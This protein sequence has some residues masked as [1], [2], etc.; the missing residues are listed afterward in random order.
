MLPAHAASAPY[1]KGPLISRAGH[2]LAFVHD[3]GVG[4]AAGLFWLSGFHSDMGGTKAVALREAARE[5]GAGFTAFDYSGHGRSGGVF[6][7]G[8]IGLWLDDALTALDTQTRG[9]QILVGSSMGG[10]LALLLA[11]QRPQR[12]AGLVLI[13]PA[14]DFTERLL[15]KRLRPAARR[16]IENEGQWLRPSAYGDA[17][18]P[19]THNLITEG[20]SHLLLPGPVP[21]SAPVRVL[22][23]MADPDVP[24][25]HAMATLNALTSPDTHLTLIRDGDH[26]L[27][28]PQDIA[29]LT[30]TVFDLRRQ[31]SQP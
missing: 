1:P 27:S 26:R 28:R 18:Y 30:R 25:R 4:G 15:W 13:A 7:H 21:V 23:G 19:I 24:W 16:Q 14:V 11:R 22:Q 9:P 5:H 29:L 3:P 12:I 2:E 6:A 10:W 20:R 8:T 17:P 31:V